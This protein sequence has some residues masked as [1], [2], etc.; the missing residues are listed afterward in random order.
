[1]GLTERQTGARKSTNEGCRMD[2]D[3]D[4]DVY[5]ENMFN[6]AGAD[7]VKVTLP[8]ELQYEKII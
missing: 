4:T 6:A 8:L 5:A 3:T 2:S 7:Y 1:M